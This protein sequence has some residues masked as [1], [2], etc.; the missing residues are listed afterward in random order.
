MTEPKDP[1]TPAQRSRQQHRDRGKY[2]K[3][4]PCYA[5][6][7]SSGVDYCSHPMTDCTDPDGRDWGD[8]ALCLCPKC[9]KATQHM[10]RVVDYINYARQKGGMK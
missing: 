6:G 7:K 2:T 3:V 4:N 5:C 9:A 8:R 1:L 10:I